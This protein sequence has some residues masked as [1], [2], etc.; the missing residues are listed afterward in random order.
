MPQDARFSGQPVFCGCFFGRVGLFL[1]CLVHSAFF[2]ARRY[3]SVRLLFV[4]LKSARMLSLDW[5]HEEKRAHGHV[6][7]HI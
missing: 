2:D 6:G 3:E 1:V 7:A 5:H 4:N